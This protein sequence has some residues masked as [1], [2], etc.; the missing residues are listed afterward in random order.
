MGVTRPNERPPEQLEG[1]LVAVEKLGP[2][3]V[4][5]LVHVDSDQS[6]AGVDYQED[7]EEDEDVNDHVGHGDDDWTSLSPHQP[8]LKSICNKIIINQQDKV[9]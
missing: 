6:E 7:E 3:V 5:D 2:V 4:V 8:S 9:V 1:R